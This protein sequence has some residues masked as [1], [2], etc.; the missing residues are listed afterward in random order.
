M[1]R[2]LFATT[3]IATLL[4]TGALAQ[5]T[6]APA[7][8]APAAETTA[9][10]PRA[11]GA[12]MS[13]IIGESVYN[14]TGDDAQNIGKVDDVVFDSSGKAKSAIIGVGGFLGVGKKDVA[15]DYAKLEWAEK[16]G[17]RW[18]VAKST[19]DELNALPAFDRKPYDPAP[20]QT[21][22]A[23][24]PANNT[25]AQAPAAAPAEPV[26]K[27]EGNIA[28]NI[29]GES[30]YNGTADDAQKIGDVNDIVLAKD[31]KA[32][33]LVIGVGGFLGIGEKNV[34]YDFA[35]AKWAEKNG[36]RWLVAETTKEELQAQPDFNRKAYD[37]APGTT[38]AANN[39]PAATTPAVVSSDTTSDKGAK[40]AEP[41]QSTAENKPAAPPAQ[42]TAENKPA[43]NGT[44]ATDQTKTSSIDKST[45]TEMPMGNIRVDDLKGTT[46][47]GANDA[48]IGS[49]GD[50]VL[51]PENKPD[52]VIIDVGGFLGIGA[53]E[54]ALGMD[55]LKFMTDKNGK[56]Y[57]YTNF[58]KEQL[59]AQTAYDKSSYAAN[60][61]QQRM[62]L[63]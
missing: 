46:V 11:N 14:G 26:K 59:Q 23:T 7:Q 19:K 48:E 50:V 17:D 53:K 21:T 8:Q 62:M 44:A 36:D 35:K 10:V 45:L 3:A 6:T 13:N 55:K 4:A 33:S 15:F 61:D 9:P 25:T 12:L 63:K 2:T 49:I 29:M 41:V 20:A 57:L 43:D 47:Y 16:N 1:I 32:E 52:A 37:P 28:S 22:D 40:P 24:Q 5:T 39:A 30:V 38:T 56:K 51:T 27:A 34:A 31:G 60:R 54:V 42:S 18:L 58:T